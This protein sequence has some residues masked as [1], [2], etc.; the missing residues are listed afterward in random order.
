MLILL[1]NK[2]KLNK[3]NNG[4][5]FYKKNLI[6]FFGDWGLGIWE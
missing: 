4:L 6:Y 2:I 3:V 5:Y 1:L